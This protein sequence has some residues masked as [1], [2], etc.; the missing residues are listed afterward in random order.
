ML[1]YDNGVYREMTPE[2][3]AAVEA[4][5]QNVK[6]SLEDRVKALE[7][8]LVAAKILLGEAE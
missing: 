2:E 5:A 8:E 1:I 4:E 6:E 7:E 3:E